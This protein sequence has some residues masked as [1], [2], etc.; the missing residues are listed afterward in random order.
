LGLSSATAART[1][2]TP[3]DLRGFAFGGTI[4]TMSVRQASA[5]VIPRPNHLT[6]RAGKM[7][8]ARTGFRSTQEPA[9]GEPRL[10]V[11][12]TATTLVAALMA[13]AALDASAA[14]SAQDERNAPTMV[15]HP[16]PKLAHATPTYAVTVPGHSD[17]ERQVEALLDTPLPAGGIAFD[18]KSLNDLASLLR[19]RL[20]IGVTLDR[21]SLEGL[22]ADAPEFSGPSVGTTHRQML[23]AWLRTCGLTYKVEDGGLRILTVDAA[24]SQ[25][26]IVIYPLPTDCVP[27]ELCELIQRVVQPTQWDAQGGPG[28]I[29]FVTQA[30]ALVVSQTQDV[31]AE[32][33]DLLRNG[34]DQD[35]GPT[36][37]P[38]NTEK[39]ARAVRAHAVPDATIRRELEKTLTEICN[40]HL[41]PDADPSATV[42]TVGDLLLVES[43]SRP[44]QVHATEMIRAIV[45]IEVAKPFLG[46][47][48]M[49]G[50][51]PAP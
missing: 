5:P 15:V 40:A 21:K 25:P 36:P 30:N 3:R 51:V 41:G 48:M 46:V 32:V 20:G 33:Q 47:G 28:S 43:S 24:A 50:G 42:R 16:Q 22:D 18:G 1:Q 13:T 9:L 34:F 49:G 31:H 14:P 12:L 8:I 27:G 6:P 29:S 17:K 37:T 19:E 11:A 39:Q 23:R 7:S 45:G 26:T 35:L 10:T 4:G 44:F 38:G 2:L